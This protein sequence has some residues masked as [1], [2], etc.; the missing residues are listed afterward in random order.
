MLIH[1]WAGISGPASL[2]MV[3]EVATAPGEGVQSWTTVGYSKCELAAYLLPQENLVTILR[4]SPFSPT[5][6]G[7]LCIGFSSFLKEFLIQALTAH[8]TGVVRQ[9][10]CDTNWDRSFPSETV[11]FYWQR[12]LALLRGISCCLRW[13]AV[14]SGV[15]VKY[16]N[17]PSTFSDY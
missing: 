2:W 17:L 4:S 10:A 16:W 8:S 6:Y 5:C 9:A 3:C 1:W 7:S 13:V 12:L 15:N 11:F 14:E